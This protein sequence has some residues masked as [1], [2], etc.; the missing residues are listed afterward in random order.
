L[1]SQF[2]IGVPRGKVCNIG[3]VEEQVA[4]LNP[5]TIMFPNPNAA[6]SVGENEFY[7]I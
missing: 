2:V 6:K 1:L 4:N 3:R 7:N 5:H